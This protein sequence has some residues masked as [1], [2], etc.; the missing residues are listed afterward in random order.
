MQT[1]KISQQPKT[2]KNR[3]DPNLGQAFLKKC[4][5]KKAP[6]LP[7]SLRLKGSIVFDICFTEF[8]TALTTI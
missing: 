8:G 2:V 5:V 6:N 3:N 7:L 1:D 4:W